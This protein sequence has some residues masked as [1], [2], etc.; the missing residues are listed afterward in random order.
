M[1]KP[2]SKKPLLK[3]EPIYQYEARDRGKLFL[4]KEAIRM[5][6]APNLILDI[7]NFEVPLEFWFWRVL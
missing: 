4:S 7:F 1:G 5:T 6:E 2:L 3:A